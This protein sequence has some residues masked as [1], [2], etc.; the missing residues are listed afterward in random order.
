[1]CKI[2]NTRTK[3]VPFYVHND[4]NKISFVRIRRQT[5]SNS[6][7]KYDIRER[8]FFLIKLYSFSETEVIF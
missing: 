3:W 1:M 7:N 2:P 8:F 5:R 4:E 6:R